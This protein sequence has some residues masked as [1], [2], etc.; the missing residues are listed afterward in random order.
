VSRLVSLEFGYC[1]PNGYVAEKVMNGKSAGDSNVDADIR[2]RE[3]VIAPLLGTSI[4]T[5]VQL[6]TIEKLDTPLSFSVYCFAIAIPILV[7]TWVYNSRPVGKTG[8]GYVDNIC[9]FGLLAGIA[10]IGAAFWH[11]SWMA[12]TVFILSSGIGIAALCDCGR[13]WAQEQGEGG[14]VNNQVEQS[15]ADRPRG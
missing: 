7:F 13:R 8:P 2:A 10:G 6:L 5:L 11:F 3:H 15:A 9:V 14:S 12:G 1:L 4:I